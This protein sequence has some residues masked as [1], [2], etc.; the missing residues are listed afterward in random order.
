[1]YAPLNGS[2]FAAAFAGAIAGMGA[3]GRA[4]TFAISS[5]PAVAASLAALAGAWAQAFDTA[6]GANPADTLQIALV[7]QLSNDRWSGNYPA[8]LATASYASQVAPL[9]AI[10]AAAE[11]YFAGQ[12]ITPPWLVSGVI[13]TAINGSGQVIPAGAVTQVINWTE[14][15]DTA[16]AFDPVAGIFTCPIAGLYAISAQSAYG[17]ALDANILYVL[18]MNAG[19]KSW[20]TQ[21]ITAVS[22]N[23]N[24][25]SA[26]PSKI[27]PLAV[28]DQ[29]KMSVFQASAVARALFV[30]AENTFLTIQQVR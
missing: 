28:G 18:S 5:D 3:S 19:A 8:S 29:V 21:A 24:G 13:A 30:S 27:V 11:T 4:P 25:Y 26:L 7:Q 23:S 9:T 10:I 12:A 22:A 1:M 17:Q 6:W 20:N 14:V 15:L 2:V 16:N